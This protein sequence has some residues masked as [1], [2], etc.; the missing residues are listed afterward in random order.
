MKINIIPI[1]GDH[2]QTLKDGRSEKY[3]AADFAIFYGVP[4]LTATAPMIW[5]IRFDDTFYNL[6]ITFFGIF[7]ALLLNVQVAI[8]SIFQRKWDKPDDEH[9]VEIQ[10]EKLSERRLLLGELN[11]NLSYMTL[12]SCFALIAFLAFFVFDV[13]AVVAAAIT[14]F[15]YAHFILTL[16]MSVK[17]AHTLFQMEYDGNC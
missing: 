17:R 7:I 14:C 8:F 15:L 16:M 6:S 10:K 3:S 9:L 5:R 12:I 13:H 1:I 4:L 11:A 2:F